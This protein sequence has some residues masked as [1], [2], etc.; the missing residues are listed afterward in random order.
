[1]I[2]KV[3]KKRAAQNREYSKLRL[4]FLTLKPKCERCGNKSTQV[5]HK[6][7]RIGN[8][9]TN[10]DFFMAVCFRCHQYIELNPN[11]AREKGWI[12]NRYIKNQ[13]Q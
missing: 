1:M 12:V 2:R 6:A 10:I 3:S 7:G 11:E 9:L 13:L 8:L 4:E 5:H